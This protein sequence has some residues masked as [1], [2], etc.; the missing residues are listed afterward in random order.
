MG[1]TAKPQGARSAEDACGE[2]RLRSAHGWWACAGG[3][4]DEP[5]GDPA[6][7]RLDQG[8]DTTAPSFVGTPL[9]ENG[10]ELERSVKIYYVVV[11]RLLPLIAGG[12]GPC[13]CLH[14]Y[15]SGR[16]CFPFT[17]QLRIFVFFFSGLVIP[18]FHDTLK[19]LL[20]IVNPALYIPIFLSMAR[21]LPF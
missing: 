6:E 15:A 21:E 4:R 8:L 2:Q 12:C 10:S 17:I 19:L 20:L 1:A 5:E 7:L 9:E 16:T 14:A 13:L 11:S 18:L 3:G